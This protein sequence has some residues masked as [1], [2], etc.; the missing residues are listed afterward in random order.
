MPVVQSPSRTTPT[1]CQ[2]EANCS[3]CFSQA[4]VLQIRETAGLRLAE[5]NHRSGTSL[6]R[7]SHNCSGFCLLLQG[8]YEENWRSDVILRRPGTLLFVAG[9]ELHSSRMRRGGIRFL[10]I[11]MTPH[12]LQRVNG[13]SKFLRG[14][15]QFDGGSLP[16]LAMR[17]YR[18]FRCGDDLA[19]LAM[20]GLVLEMLAGVIR[21][22]NRAVE[23]SADW[24]KSATDFLHD[25]FDQP[26]AL[27]DVAK[28]ADV[29]PVSLAR[30]FRR[31][32][33]CTVGDYIRRLRIEF[34]CRKLSRSDAPLVEIALSAGFSEH[35]H[36]SRTFKQVTGLTPSDYRSAHQG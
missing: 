30:A 6:A 1:C 24:L 5:A 16:W 26:L 22:S 17:L 27:S 29:H 23:E 13:H 34:A 33:H 12:W 9:G 35:S 15:S 20:E 25:R 21:E 3:D 31:R 14:L 19:L 36:F 28:A 4:E 7:H 32:H 10:S 2:I 11:E 18:E 8:C